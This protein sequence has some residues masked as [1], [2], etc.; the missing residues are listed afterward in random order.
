[1]QI[2]KYWKNFSNK[3]KYKKFIEKKIKK[4]ISIIRNNSHKYNLLFKNI[5]TYY[6]SKIITIIIIFK[7]ILFMRS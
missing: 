3:M 5:C 4:I 7:V 1:M 2:I 6:F